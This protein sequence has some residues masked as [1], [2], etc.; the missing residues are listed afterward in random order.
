MATAPLLTATPSGDTLELRPGGSWTAANAATLERLSGDIA[1]QLDSAGIVK[2]DMAGVRE[3]DTLGAWLL[4]KMSR[5]AT[6]AGHRADIVG[7]A[8]NYS[9]LIDEIRQV[10]RRTPAPVPVRN[11]IV[12]KLGEIGRGTIGASEDITAF[13]QMLGSLCIAILG[14]LRRPRS[15]RLTSLTYQLYRVGWQ[16]IPIIVLITFLIGPSSRSKAFSISENSARI[17][18]SST[19]LAFSCCGNSA[20]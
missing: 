15:L 16:A 14:V 8:D 13:L 17:P 4:E 20:C 18:T 10:N 2:V 7:I 9:G 12:T 1:P 6:S 3:L 11:P 19:W 5:R